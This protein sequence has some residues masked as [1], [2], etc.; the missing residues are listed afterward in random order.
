MISRYFVK[1]MQDLA[2]SGSGPAGKKPEASAAGLTAIIAR[3]FW[4]P[5]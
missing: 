1:T 5:M 4:L 3:P 2:A